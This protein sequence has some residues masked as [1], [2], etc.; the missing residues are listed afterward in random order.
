MSSFRLGICLFITL[1]NVS[2][3]FVCT[4][5]FVY[6][7]GTIST[8]RK[9]RSPAVGQRKSRFEMIRDDIQ[10]SLNKHQFTTPGP[11][12]LRAAYFISFGT[13]VSLFKDIDSAHKQTFISKYT[14]YLPTHD[15]QTLFRYLQALQIVRNRCAHGNHIITKKMTYELSPQIKLVRPPLSPFNGYATPLEAVLLFLL[16]TSNCAQEFK[17]DLR[18]LLKKNDVILSKYPRFHSLSI[19]VIK[20]LGL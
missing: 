4:A 5:F 18:A 12:N 7:F 6:Q 1:L 9:P 8:R 11:S 20:N 3:S 2:T 13:F 14:S 19:N 17:K 15:Y 16:K 10:A